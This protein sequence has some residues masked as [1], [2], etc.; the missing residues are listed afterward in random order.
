[1]ST[2]LT[3]ITMTRASYSD[4]NR[5]YSFNGLTV[6]LHVERIDYLLP[7]VVT[8]CD[9]SFLAVS[10]KSEQM[11]STKCIDVRLNDA[12][13]CSD[14]ETHILSQDM[15]DRVLGA[16]QRC[17]N[18]KETA[19]FRCIDILKALTELHVAIAKSCD[20]D[21]YSMGAVAEFYGISGCRSFPSK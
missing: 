20:K 17:I 9:K 2:P 1:M 3:A 4:E 11:D 5:R 19:L 6:D 13:I 21:F 12:G 16:F 7:N 8:F 10:W 15:Y 14:H 18:S